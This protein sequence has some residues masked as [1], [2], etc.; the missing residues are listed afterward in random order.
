MF[1]FGLR[2]LPQK[3]TLEEYSVHFPELQK[4][5]VLAALAL[6]RTAADLSKAFDLH[7]AAFGITE[8]RFII[9]M[10]LYRESDYTLDFTLLSEKAEITKST[11]TG[12]IDG[13]E[14]QGYVERIPHPKDRR[15]QLLRLSSSGLKL[16]E[17]MLPK[18]YKKTGHLMVG[19]SLSEQLDLIN[20]LD[21]LQESLLKTEKREVVEHEQTIY[22]KRK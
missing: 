11:L 4:E 14:K 21:K 15:K 3:E 8:G 1:E 22:C 7:F 19:L 12:L 6:L 16:L 13:L 17:E 18:H 9:L 20:L 10:L 5:A 2:D